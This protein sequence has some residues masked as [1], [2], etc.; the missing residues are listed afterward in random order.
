[1]IVVQ[2]SMRDLV[3]VHGF[4]GLPCAAEVIVVEVADLAKG[5]PSMCS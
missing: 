2:R 1:M 5:V 4:H 3:F